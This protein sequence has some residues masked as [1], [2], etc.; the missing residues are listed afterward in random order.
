MRIPCPYCGARG[1]R[2]SPISATPPCA[3][4]RSGSA[5]TTRLRAVH[6]YVYLRDN[7]AGPHRELWYHGAGCHAWLVVTR[8]TR[9]HEIVGVELAREVALTRGEPTIARRHPAARMDE[10]R[11]R[12]VGRTAASACTRP[13]PIALAAGGLIDRSR[14]L[15]LHLRRPRL[16]RPCRRHAGLGA[17]RQRRAAGRPL[18]QV[19]PAA[20]HPHRRAGGAERAGRAAHR[21]AARAEHRAT[22][23]E[24]YDGLEAASQ[25]RWPSLA[26]RPAGGQL[27]G[28][29]RCC[30]AGFYYKTFMWPA[31]F[32]ERVYEPLIRRAAGLGRA[33]GEPDPDHYEKAFLH[34][35]TCWSS[36]AGRPGLRRR[37]RRARTGARVILCDEDFR[38][39]GRLLADAARSTAGRR[40]VGRA[41]RRRNCAALPDVR[42]MPR[43]TVFGVYDGGTYWRARARRRSSRRAAAA[44]AAPAAV[45]HRR[46][47]LRARGRRD[48]AAAGVRRQRPARRDAG[49]RRAHLR[50]PLR[51]RRRA[52]RRGL[53]QQRRDGWRTAAD[54]ARAGVARGGSRRQPRAEVP[55]SIAAAAKATGARLIAGGAVDRGAIGARACARSTVRT[56]AGETETHR[57]RSRSPCPAAGIPTCI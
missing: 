29:R 55:A 52:A 42:I 16:S 40:A 28:S 47:A 9:T 57:L 37:W 25:N 51:G 12:R 14:A 53:H 27:A 56:A 4:R 22:T 45:A 17:A 21:R 39:G 11:S 48:R 35:A 38:L 34:S 33:A 3:R 49:G 43:T 36:A 54:L 5:P 46:Q 23:V 31:S 1:T 19:S 32:W 30:R 6:D 20:R 7:P 8:D 18:V 26:L 15:A 13:A 44:R 2:S 24:L 10:A 41:R 50:Q